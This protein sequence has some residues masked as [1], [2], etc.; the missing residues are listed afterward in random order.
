MFV[1][2]GS[3]YSCAHGVHFHWEV[4]FITAHSLFKL[5]C[6]SRYL[7][8]LDNLQNDLSIF[9]IRTHIKNKR[10]FTIF[11]IVSSYLI[12]K[13]NLKSVSNY[14]SVHNLNT[15]LDKTSIEFG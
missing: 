2:E 13:I 3:V 7:D 5:N 9:Y 15:R 11:Q 14:I 8:L 10:L 1:E 12:E 4:S 6:I